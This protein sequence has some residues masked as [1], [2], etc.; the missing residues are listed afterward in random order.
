L[1]ATTS[2]LA[3]PF[4]PS[5]KTASTDVPQVMASQNGKVKVAILTVSD[6]VSSGAGPDR[7]YF[8]IVLHAIA[9]DFFPT[10]KAN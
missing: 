2:P 8:C 3:S 1:P 5:A 9:C 6:T 4:A 7:R 10:V